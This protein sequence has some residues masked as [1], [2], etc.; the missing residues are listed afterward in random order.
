MIFTPDIFQCSDACFKWLFLPKGKVA[1]LLMEVNF[2]NN[3][4]NLSFHMAIV[5]QENKIAQN[6]KLLPSPYGVISRSRPSLSVNFT[7]ISAP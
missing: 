3:Q 4:R 7:T 1:F 5:L 2:T 6:E